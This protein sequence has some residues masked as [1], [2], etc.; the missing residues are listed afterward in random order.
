[1]G[2]RLVGSVLDGWLCFAGVGASS[3]SLALGH[4]ITV[5]ALNGPFRLLCKMGTLCDVI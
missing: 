1:M 5:A 4:S 2:E 3:V